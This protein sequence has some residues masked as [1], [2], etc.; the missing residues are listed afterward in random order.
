M[1]NQP[2][3]E[4]NET[5]A[6][7]PEAPAAPSAPETPTA[8]QA[9]AKKKNNTALIVVLVCVFVALPIISV[10]AVFAIIGNYLASHPELAQKIEDEIDR[11]TSSNYVAGTWDCANGTGSKN[12]RDNYSVTLELN[13]DMTFRYG[14]YGD[15]KKNHYGGTYTFKDEDK[16][17]KDGNYNYYMVDFDTNELIVDG[18][19]QELTS[20]KRLS[21]MEMGITKTSNGKEAIIIFVSSYNMYYCYNDAK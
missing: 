19:E 6:P 9:P 3:P 20:G 14:K 18:E 2:A 1:D 17:T 8:P 15:L 21:Q 12:D 13:N 5:N 7:A 10:I 16:Q 11:Q 4:T